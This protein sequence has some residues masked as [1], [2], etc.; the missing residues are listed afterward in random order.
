[1]EHSEGWTQQNLWNCYTKNKVEFAKEKCDAIFDLLDDE[2]GRL[3]CYGTKGVERGYDFCVIEYSGQDT[4]SEFKRVQ[5]F[6]ENGVVNKETCDLKGKIYVWN[7]EKLQNCYKKAG[8]TLNKNFCKT[9]YASTSE[10]LLNER[11]D[12]YVTIGLNGK[13]DREYCELLYD[14][15]YNMKNPTCL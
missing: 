7:D 4:S 11:Y 1:M 14:K 3:Q 6:D 10:V 8:Y 9:Y 15:N 2:K 13:K 12:C 5:C